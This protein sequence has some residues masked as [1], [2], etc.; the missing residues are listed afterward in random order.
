M[1][2]HTKSLVE[3]VE[4]NTGYPVK[5][6]VTPGLPTH[7]RMAS[8]RPDAPFHL[9]EVNAKH[10]SHADYIVAAQCSMLLVSWSD[11]SAVRGISM[12]PEEARR[13]IETWSKAEPSKFPDAAKNPELGTFYLRGLLNQVFSIPMEIVVA[14][15]L[16]AEAPSLRA[17]QQLLQDAYLRQMSSMFAPNFRAAFPEEVFRT[18][19]AMAAALVTN[20]CQLTG[21]TAPLIP[22][23]SIG[24]V[25]RGKHLLALTKDLAATRTSASL[26]KSVDD[27]AE[28]LSLR[29]LYTWEFSDRRS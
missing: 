11:P 8:G 9:I 1:D 18:N 28:F 29:P 7:A 27:W 13:R 10:R 25:E 26:A 23:E 19:A 16:F 22:Y 6:E 15:R 5:V 4:R 20:W 14:G 21:Q 24:A 3:E 12:C 17:S 2:P